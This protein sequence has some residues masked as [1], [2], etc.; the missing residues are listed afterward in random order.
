MIDAARRLACA[1]ALVCTAAQ[2]G[3]PFVTDDP[4]PVDLH[5]WEINYGATF[6]HAQ[7]TSSGALPGVDLN[8]GAY[9]NVQL[10]A[11]PQ[12]AYVRGPGG[13]AA[14]FGDLELGVKYR[15][16]PAGQPRDAWMVGIY[17]ML[18]L[19]TGSARRGLG[20]G[21]CSAYLPLWVQ[22]TRGRWT[23]FGG[24]G[25]WL[26][27]GHEGRNAWAGGVTALYAVSERLQLGAEF[28]GST[29]RH[30]DERGA[31]GVN[32]GG[33][34]QLSDGLALLFS[35]GHGVRNASANNEGAAYL[36]LRTA[37]QGP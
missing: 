2:A 4:E 27:G 19:P 12:L 8:Y 29:P 3:P 6:L 21:A 25:Y 15:F 20:A 16:T 24:G 10:H 18:E 30:V 37:F 31:T 5:A 28:Y 34:L 17:P 7:G 9:E 14:G 23:V 13:N 32:V 26:D 35:V 11:Q 36:G 22:T 1:A 33:T